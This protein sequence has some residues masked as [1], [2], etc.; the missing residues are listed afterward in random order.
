MQIEVTQVATEIQKCISQLTVAIKEVK[1]RAIRLAEAIANYDRQM[2]VTMMQLK[3]GMEFELDGVKIK[4]VT[5]TNME[6]FAKGICWQPKLNME[7][8][9]ALYKS[10]IT[11]IETV[12]AQLNGW[13]SINRYLES[14]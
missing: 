10:S 12:K 9:E 4:D 14:R 3:N 5:A 8:A 7:E 6:R 11:Y 1:E 2:A 13:Q